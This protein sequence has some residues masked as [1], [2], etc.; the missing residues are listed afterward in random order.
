MRSHLIADVPLGLFLS[1]GLDSTALVALASRE[2]KGLHTFTIV[3]PEQEFSESEIARR[4][5]E[6]FGTEHRELMVSAE[7]MVARLPQ[8][9]G[10]LDQPSMDGINTYFRLLGGAASGLEGRALRPGR[11]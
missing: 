7:D 6:R 2:R 8:A 10:A 9:V 1:S 11:R 4:T 5:A 3:F